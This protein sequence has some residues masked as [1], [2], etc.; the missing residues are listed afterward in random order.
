MAAAYE[1]LQRPEPPPPPLTRRASDPGR[2]SQY[3]IFIHRS[4]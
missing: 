3:K 2:H 1:A 4:A